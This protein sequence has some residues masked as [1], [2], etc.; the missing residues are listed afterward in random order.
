MQDPFPRIFIYQ[1]IDPQNNSCVVKFAI[2]DG[3]SL[4]PIQKKAHGTTKSEAL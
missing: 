2:L 4:D 1:E 3:E